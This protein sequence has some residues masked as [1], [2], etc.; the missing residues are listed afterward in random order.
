MIGLTKS[1]I[2]YFRHNSNWW[3][4]ERIWWD[5]WKVQSSVHAKPRTRLRYLL[6]CGFFLC[7]N[8][9]HDVF[10]LENIPNGKKDYKGHTTG[11]DSCQRYQA[12]NSKKNVKKKPDE[13]SSYL[14]ICTLGTI[15]LL[16]R[17]RNLH[18]S[19]EI[20]SGLKLHNQLYI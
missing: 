6:S 18:I 2:E 16:I 20:M 10:Q 14:V 4:E 1:I 19:P 12:S 13:L 3:N 9:G 7:S 15:K 17:I 5:G 11:L 8:V